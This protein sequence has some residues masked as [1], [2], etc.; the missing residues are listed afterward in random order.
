MS[1]RDVESTAAIEFRDVSMEFGEK[2]ALEEVTFTLDAGST[3]VVTGA[4]A[5][6]KSVLL[7]LAMGLERP[8]SGSILIRGTPI[9]GLAEEELL[10]IRGGTMGFVF[11]ENALFT[12]MTAFSNTAFRLVEHGWPAKSI[13]AEVMEILRF[14]GLDAHCDKLPE[15]LSIGM[16]RRL[17]IARAL[18]G[19]PPIMLYDEATSGLD[20]INAKQVMDLTIRARDVHGISALYVTKEMHEILYLSRHAAVEGP[21][22][23]EIVE[24][25]PSAAPD[26]RVMLLDGG[27]V[28][29]FGSGDELFAS[30]DP[31]VRRMTHPETIV[32]EPKL[33]R[34]FRA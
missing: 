27:R 26:V 21:E 22:G 16:R 30:R 32:A 29:F 5:S 13:E 19:W 6:G 8:S 24:C 9:E 31:A 28:E 34:S 3:I 23:I 10:E 17:E 20:P 18:V 12:G 1:Q 15:E 4:S 2:R 25:T 33:A 7:R 11:Q 14:V